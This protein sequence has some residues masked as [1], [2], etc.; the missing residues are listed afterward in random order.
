MK[1]HA[2]L[3]LV[4]CGFGTLKAQNTISFTMSDSTGCAPLAITFTNTSTAPG[5]STYSWDFGDGTFFTGKNAS[6]TYTA[7]GSYYVQ[8]TGYNPSGSPIGT[9]SKV[10]TVN[11][12]ENNMFSS[13]QAACPGENIAFSYYA[14]LPY[15]SLRW[16]FGDGFSSTAEYT[17]HSY[18]I[19]GI[20]N[21]NLYV[22]TICGA[23]TFS[24]TIDI[25]N[26]VTPSV[27]FYPDMNTVCPGMPVTFYP[28]GTSGTY[29]W[30]FGDG[31]TSTVYQPSHTYT[32][33]GK[34]I[35][36]LSVTNLCG[37]TGVYTDSITVDTNYVFPQLFP[38]STPDPA[39]PNDKIYFNLYSSGPGNF[40]SY[41]WNFGDGAVS[42]LQS[43]IHSYTALGIY[44][45]SI[46]VSQCSKDTTVTF[47]VTIDNTNP[48]NPADFAYGAVIDT[49]CPGDSVLFYGFGGYAY[50][51]DFG[52]GSPIGTATQSFDGADLIL[53]AYSTT[54]TYVVK[55]T[56]FNGC[57]QSFT[58]SLTVTVTNSVVPT[59]FFGWV[60]QGNP[61]SS[62]DTV[63]FIA[64]GGSSYTWDFGDGA[65]ITTSSATIDH[66]YTAAGTF[67][68]NLTVTNGCGNTASTA[69]VIQISNCAVGIESLSKNNTLNIYP[70]PSSGNFT[71]EIG[72]LELPASITV[73]NSLGAA[74][75]SEKLY[76]T[77]EHEKQIQLKNAAA[78]LY[79]I[80]VISGKKVMQQKA[81]IQ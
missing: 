61:I 73:Y 67:N 12:A 24:L 9:D 47:P 76:S 70:N 72:D 53:H 41:L 71:L 36:S 28:Y 4:L 59:P 31:N 1:K 35:V 39:C 50:A 6:H 43:P 45:V 37:N 23:D 30:D 21:V 46:T 32:A 69:D 13:V 62:C 5:N 74:V 60:N 8:L 3:L 34:Y 26:N 58:D 65:V 66:Q 27:S 16:N 63:H 38:Y 52:D 55:V 64:F 56:V 77:A 25:N 33:L 78:G 18:S 80:R 22:Y 42:S 81:V 40:S 11:G 68:I 51:W 20:Y 48:I 79:F 29:M 54:G 75:F 49:V 19:T 7:A 57:M 17:D 14:W 44:N 15:D 10:V 2:I